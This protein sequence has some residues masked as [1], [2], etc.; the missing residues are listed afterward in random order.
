MTYHFF[1]WFYKFLCD[2][3]FGAWR[4]KDVQPY[5]SSLIL[6]TIYSESNVF[7]LKERPFI[8]YGGN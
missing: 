2:I 8:I 1:N 4:G 3:E 5:E 7:K 6:S